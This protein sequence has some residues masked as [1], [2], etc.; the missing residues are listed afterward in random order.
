MERERLQPFDVIVPLE[1]VTVGVMQASVADGAV[2]FEQDGMLG[3]H[4]R[5]VPGTQLVN[6]GAVVSS[7]H[8]QVLVHVEE[9]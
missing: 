1:H 8:V 3:L 4:P 7:V 6:A 9:F 5:S 2:T